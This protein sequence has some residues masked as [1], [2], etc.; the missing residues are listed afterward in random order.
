MKP[1]TSSRL[2][3]TEN[4]GFIKDVSDQ[5]VKS[6]FAENKFLN[7]IDLGI[8]ENSLLPTRHFFEKFTDTVRIWVNET[9]TPQ[10]EVRDGIDVE[11]KES[12]RSLGI[13]IRNK[14]V[15]VPMAREQ[16]Y[17]QVKLDRK[18]H[19]YIRRLV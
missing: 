15:T 1:Q 4:P 8:V 11:I 18:S 5:Q 19:E 16:I 14:T 10:P 17:N 12:L 2:H 13:D 6:Y 9:S 3:A 7:Q